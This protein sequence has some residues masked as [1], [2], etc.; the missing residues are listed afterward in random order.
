MKQT[1][2][3]HYRLLFLTQSQVVFY[4]LYFTYF[5]YFFIF[6]TNLLHFLTEEKQDETPE[7]AK[8]RQNKLTKQ[9]S[10]GGAIEIER[11]EA[12]YLE[13]QGYI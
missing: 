12:R 11:L 8:K 3:F 7:W 5:C 10:Q 6:V 13:S 9:V 2:A 1:F 4:I